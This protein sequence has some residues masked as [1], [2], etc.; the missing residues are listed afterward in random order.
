MSYVD[1][2]DRLYGYLTVKETVDFAF[3]C[4]YG[5]SHR[6]PFSTE[7]PEI[8]SLIKELDSKGWLVDI[9]LRGVGLKR[10]EDTFVGNDRVRG[11]SGGE[12]K[13]LSLGCEL[14]GSPS[15]LFLDEPT[16]GLDAA[17]AEK[18]GATDHDQG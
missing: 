3:Q 13:R 4:S 14:V 8:E 6:G 9:I 7:G 17:A 10:V 16:S 11:V 15:L 2:I 18:V 5:G 12:K 1:Q